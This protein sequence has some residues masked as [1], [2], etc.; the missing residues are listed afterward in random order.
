[1]GI[2]TFPFLED[3]MMRT[4]F[5]DES[6]PMLGFGM[7]RLP[8][9]GDGSIDEERTG[10]MVA[11]AMDAGVNYFDTAWGYHDGNSELVAGR[12][13][14]KYPRGSYYLASKF[15]GYDVSNMGK[16]A[17][18]F[19]KQLEK[20]Q[21][22]YFDF[23]LVHN[24]FDLNIDSY[25]DPGYGTLE[26][27]REERR[28][29]RIRHLGFS[30][31]GSVETIERFLEMYG[32]DMEFIQLQVN[33]V[34]WNFQDAR[35]KVELAR[36]H[37]LPVWVMEPIRGGKLARVGADVEARIGE[38]VPGASPVEA[39]FRFVQ[40]I[41]G[42][43]VVLSGLSDEDQTA[44]NISI[45][46]K[47]GRLSDEE[48]DALVKIGD[49][50]VSSDTVPCTACNYCKS[51]CPKGLDIPRLL[52]LYN[53]HRFTNGG[54]FGPAFVGSMPEDKRPSACIGCGACEKVCPQG[55]RISDAMRDFVRRL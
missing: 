5:G 6:L 21:T 3:P 24:V 45:F 31:H 16:T 8:L 17:E 36:R 52:E 1:M 37:G 34:D 53:E 44:Q 33:Y 32:E 39:A 26:A 9:K 43:K 20:C 4:A 48:F 28:K 38:T 14:S 54:F 50:I 29:G 46:S 25:L 42:V 35:A 22:E 2:Y 7:M 19:E 30:A 18:I 12:I 49:G 23:Y 40:S 11:E 13:L 27:L 10:R 41:D 15:P 51:K 47:D 55:I